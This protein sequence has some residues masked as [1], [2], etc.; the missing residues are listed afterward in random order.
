MNRDRNQREEFADLYS[1]LT[2]TIDDWEVIHEFLSRHPHAA[3]VRY[4][5]NETPLQ[6]ALKARG[7]RQAGGGNGERIGRMKVVQ[8]LM[9]SDPSSIFSRDEEGRTCLHTACSAGVSYLILMMLM[10]E[11]ER[12]PQLFPERNVVLRTDF[13]S[14]ALPLHSIAACPLMMDTH[15]KVTTS[16]HHPI[17]MYQ[18]ICTLTPNIVAAYLST[19]I[20]R[21]ANPQAVWDRD[22]DGEIP[23]HAAASWGNV[24]AVLSLLVGAAAVIGEGR[25]A[26]ESIQRAAVTKDDRNKTPLHRACDRI[27]S[28]ASVAEYSTHHRVSGGFRLSRVREDPFQTS[29]TDESNRSLLH[30]SQTG[31]SRRRGRGLESS[32]RS[33]FSSSFARRGGVL[34]EDADGLSDEPETFP[35]LRA[36]FISPRRSI[37]RR[38][39][40]PLDCDS[41]EEFAKVEML[42]RAAYGFFDTEGMSDETPEDNA[43]SIIPASFPEEDTNKSI[44]SSFDLLLHAVIE[45]GCPPEI[46]WHALAKTNQK[47]LKDKLGRT[48]LCVAVDRYIERFAAYSFYMNTDKLVEATEKSMTPDLID[49]DRKGSMNEVQRETTSPDGMESD[50]ASKFVQS[51]LLGYPMLESGGISTL[52]SDP[53]VLQPP[54]PKN[55]SV[56]KAEDISTLLEEM[57]LSEETINILVHSEHGLELASIPNAVGRL[58]LHSLLEA[59]VQWHDTAHH[60]DGGGEEYLPSDSTLLKTLVE[61]YPAALETAVD[62]KAGELFPFM[63]AAA[64]ASAAD[65][66]RHL[67]TILQLLL[68]APNALSLCQKAKGRLA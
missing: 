33:S 21:K 40:I 7:R 10:K 61:A 35:Q 17:N 27:C 55:T 8:T 51:L 53:K 37:G 25:S 50:P 58:P 1:L 28:L 67:E 57:L 64:H 20:I 14:G 5:R 32:L 43:A 4:Y 19:T 38:I 24:G 3:Q 26:S 39:F 6:L 34:D 30:S 42:A 47:T 48:P 16:K 49:T 12:H 62:T 65:G 59:G 11:E 23:L 45:L 66:A 22:C 31:N 52:C 63:M 29:N 18:L 36:S 60:D 68:K 46:V 15:A 41:T 2:Q 44:N 13:P 54:S 9:E 56:A